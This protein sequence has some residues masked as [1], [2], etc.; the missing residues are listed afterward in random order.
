MKTRKA[1]T[2]VEILI[3][4]ILLGIL[5]TIA[6][7]SFGDAGADTELAAAKTTCTTVFTA[8]QLAITDPDSVMVGVVPT[9]AELET[10]NLLSVDTGKWTIVIAG[11]AAAP[12][13]VVTSATNAAATYSLPN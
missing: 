9:V 1:F 3:V 10:A 12:T 6:I 13:V 2:L 7:S 8:V 5:A 11:T 4:V